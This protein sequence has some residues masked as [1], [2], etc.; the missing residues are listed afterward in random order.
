MAG[1]KVPLYTDTEDTIHVHDLPQ[2][3]QKPP[4]EGLLRALDTLCVAPPSFEVAHITKKR[5]IIDESGVPTYLTSIVASSLAWVQSDDARERI[6]DAA[7]LRLSER[8]GRAAMP[9]MTRTF[10]VAD[11]VRIRLHEPSLTG[12]NLGLKTW[13]SSL[14]LSKRL[15]ALRRYVPA[16]KPKLLELGAGTGLVGISAACLWPAKVVLTD[17]PEIVSNLEQNLEMNQELITHMRGSAAARALDWSDQ[18]D[19]PATADDKFQVI[20]AADPIYSPD[21]PRILVDAIQRWLDFSQDA[22]A[23]IELP[24]RAHYTNERAQLRALLRA[25]GLELIVEGTEAGMDD[26][27]DDE[28]NQAQVECEWSVWRPSGENKS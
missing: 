27:L 2:L 6:W 21:H 1:A 10:D 14:L 26:W 23:I 15:P 28:G 4:A 20:I 12:D 9:A 16:G 17:L 18:L 3:W 13:V 7:S 22:R 5:S 11:G 8:S 24:L 25:A 19:A